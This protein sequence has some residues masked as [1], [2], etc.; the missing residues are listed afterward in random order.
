MMMNLSKR[1]ILSLVGGIAI[2]GIA[3]SSMAQADAHA[4]KGKAPAAAQP[5]HK[6]H[7]DKANKDDKA[8]GN[9]VVN[10]G[11]EAPAI[12]LKDTDGKTVKLSDFKG[13]IVVLEWF[14]PGCPYVVKHHGKNTTMV[15][16][17]N[18][19][20]DKGVVWLAINSGAPG[21]EGAGQEA[22]ATAKKEWKIPFPILLDESGKVGKSY[23][24]KNT[25]AMFVIDANGK[26]AYMA[27]GDVVDVKTHK[28]VGL[29]RDEYGRLMDSEKVLDLAFNLEGKM[30]RKVNE[31]AIGDPQAYAARMAATAKQTKEASK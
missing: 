14:N 27:S 22:S 25:P 9:K 29:L 3:S 17:F 24:A 7:K 16:T 11:Q 19:F 28:I 1:H 2:L 4:P 18:K 8:Q 10:I 20:K 23:G 12:E 5:E 15:D 31:F 13:K 6:E 30:V 26:L 21:N